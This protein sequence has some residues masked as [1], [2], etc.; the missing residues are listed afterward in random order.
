MRLSVGKAWSEA[1]GVFARDGGLIATVAL[2]LIVLPGVLVGLA[3]PATM[4]DPPAWVGPVSLLAGFLSLTGQLAISR[5]ALGPPLT[6]GAAIGV[7]FRR[8]PVFLGGA[9]LWAGPFL[10]VMIGLL[11][12]AGADLTDPAAPLPTP[13]VGVT[14]ALMLLMLLF[15]VVAVRMLLTTP[16]AAGSAM[17]PIA[18]VRHSWQASRGNLLRL[19]GLLLGVL[20][21]GVVIV[22]GLGSAISSVVILTLGA[23]EP[24]N[25]SALLVA[26]IQ[27]LLNAMLSV[28]LA[29]VVARLYAQTTG[30]AAP[31]AV[32]DAGERS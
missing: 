27:Q 19:L 32:S 7:G 20:L 12:A 23:P 13:P 11:A 24:W 22:V 6:V 4:R 1:R 2:A 30:E 25:V 10:L 3:A 31:V 26:L 14:L 18:V 15:L 17:G 16:A 21:L 8:L 28:G 29:V 9:L 5:I